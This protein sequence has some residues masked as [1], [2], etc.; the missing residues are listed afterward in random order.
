MNSRSDIRFVGATWGN[1]FSAS[2][3]S[4]VP[5]HLFGE[6]EKM[7]CLM[8]RVDLK[9]TKM[10]DLFRGGL[11]WKRTLIAKELRRNAF[12]R[13]LPENI[14]RLSTRMRNPYASLP[15]H[16]AV[17]QFGV[18]GMPEKTVPLIAHVEIT[19]ETAASTPAFSS[20]YGFSVRDQKILD[21]A[22]E[23]EQ[24]FLNRCDLIWTNSSWTAQ[25]FRKQGVP[26]EKLWVQA[27]GCEV[28]ADNE[29]HRR[30]EIPHI[31]FVGK[32]W[33]RKGGPLLVESF[34]ILKQRYPTSQLTIIGCNPAISDEGIRVLGF[35]DKQNPEHAALL[36]NVYQEA[37][38]FC[39]PSLWEST[40]I[41]Y[42]EA[43]QHGLPVVMLK[44]QGREDIFPDSMAII[45]DRPNCENL[46]SILVQLASDPVRMET[47][48]RAGRDYVLKNFT[49]PV[50]S[51][52][53]KERIAHFLKTD[54]R[55]TTMRF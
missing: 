5:Y 55:G 7:G 4:G 23:G 16:D 13:Y 53:L 25:G 22:I 32:D 50:I 6:L 47:M 37:T 33:E 8:G 10:T 27:P 43:A 2:T 42:M 1:P 15:D 17:I 19:I 21:R 38:I 11:D 46:A 35:L 54:Q 45:L 49:W 34:S 39:M 48:G 51:R 40:G 52:R 44:G 20:S 3:Y 9:Q 41:V 14:D 24:Q 26:Q 18:A 28:V 31:L 29:V 12:W 36:E 30:W